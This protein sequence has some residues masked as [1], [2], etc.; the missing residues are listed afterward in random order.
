MVHLNKKYGY[1][2]LSTIKSRRCRFKM[3]LKRDLKEN[4]TRFNIYIL[5]VMMLTLFLLLIP[6]VFINIFFHELGHQIASLIIFPENTASQNIIRGYAS[7]GGQ[8][9]ELYQTIIIF[10]GGPL[11]SLILLV[12]VVIMMPKI[13]KD[14]RILRISLWLL[15][16]LLISNSTGYFA[17]AYFHRLI[18]YSGD[19]INIAEGL[20]WLWGLN[21]PQGDS[22]IDAAIIFSTIGIIASLPFLIYAIRGI[23]EDL[24][25]YF[26]DFIQHDTKKEKR[27]GTIKIFVILPL[28][29]FLTYLFWTLFFNI[30]STGSLVLS[31]WIGLDDYDIVQM[32]SGILVLSTL[33]AILLL[34][35]YITKEVDLTMS[36]RNNKFF[37]VN[38]LLIFFFLMFPYLRISLMGETDGGKY[39]E[40]SYKDM[41]TSQE[42]F[43][44]EIVY[45][46]QTSIWSYGVRIYSDPGLEPS[47]TINL[48]NHKISFSE[49]DFYYQNGLSAV[50]TSNLSLWVFT[51][52]QPDLRS[53]PNGNVTFYGTS[54]N[55]SSVDLNNPPDSMSWES[56][57]AINYTGEASICRQLSN[58]FFNP[59]TGEIWVL[60]K[61]Q[62]AEG[63]IYSWT[64]CYTGEGSTLQSPI[65][66]A[67]IN[68][69]S[70]S[71][72][73]NKELGEDFADILPY[74]S[75]YNSETSILF[76]SNDSLVIYEGS[77]GIETMQAYNCFTT[78][79]ESKT[80]YSNR[81][82]EYFQGYIIKDDKV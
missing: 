1:F 7:G 40:I 33:I 68:P 50:M 57:L 81:D 60:Y 24:L 51:F 10:G 32:M 82:D 42:L 12:I 4:K 37:V 77:E 43:E 66:F 16:F 74:R 21:S 9:T 48:F 67:R 19:T 73:E 45:D 11:F 31:S 13:Q 44:L 71:I 54:Y 2:S 3:K 70:S 34:N 18:N 26:K 56:R 23:R 47:D 59:D 76:S 64:D 41:P 80:I 62:W 38:V 46:Y 58:A 72:I 25:I 53:D 14:H 52:E 63:D 78:K 5:I 22:P 15:I 6:V 75:P 8:R 36:E 17:A 65:W 27:I 28:T 69:N 20:N 79:D 39:Y 55:F 29:G 35:H 49:Y 30:D 61:Y